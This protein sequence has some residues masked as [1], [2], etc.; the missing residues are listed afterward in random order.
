M[1]IQNERR[2]EQLH[3]I[4]DAFRHA[5]LL[6]VPQVTQT[7]KILVDAPMVDAPIRREIISRGSGPI[8]YCQAGWREACGQSWAHVL[9][10]KVPRCPRCGSTVFT[11]SG[12]GPYA[13]HTL[14]DLLVHYNNDHKLGW[15]DLAK[16]V[17]KL[18]DEK[19]IGRAMPIPEEARQ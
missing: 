16:A 13:L 9:D 12:R 1:L 17:D 7:G 6:D 14:G 8:A 11:M 19:T 5:A 15:L 10:E 3:A 2:V 4:R 18:T